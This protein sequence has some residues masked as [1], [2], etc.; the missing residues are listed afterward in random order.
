M[1]PA[2]EKAVRGSIVGWYLLPSGDFLQGRVREE[3]KEK[4]KWI[5][6]ASAPILAGVAV[7]PPRSCGRLV[8]WGPKVRS[9]FHRARADVNI[10]NEL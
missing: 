5:L 2:R 7:P 8:S 9:R 4:R 6:R 10:G 3:E 1:V